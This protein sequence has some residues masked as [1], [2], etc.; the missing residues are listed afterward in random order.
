MINWL[1]ANELGEGAVI[2]YDVGC[3]LGGSVKKSKLMGENAER[4]C[5]KFGEFA[6][7]G[8]KF[9]GLTAQLIISSVGR[10]WSER[11]MATHTTETVRWNSVPVFKKVWV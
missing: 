6:N 9:A 5:L 10:Q 8:Y 4:C 7:P 3:R 2:G 1:M 11:F